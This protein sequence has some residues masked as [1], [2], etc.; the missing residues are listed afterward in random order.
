MKGFLK[1]LGVAALAGVG[2]YVSSHLPETLTIVH[3]PD[4]FKFPIGTAIG[5]AIAHWLPRPNERKE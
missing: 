2:G 4:A 3:V 5:A 1:N